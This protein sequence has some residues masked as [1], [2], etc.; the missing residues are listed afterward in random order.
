MT[1]VWLSMEHRNFWDIPR[2]AVVRFE[3]ET[4][5]FDCPFSDELDEYP[6]FFT[7]YRIQ[8]DVPPSG[9]SWLDLTDG[10]E[11]VGHIPARDVRFDPTRR[12][13]IAAETMQ[14]ILSESQEK[15]HA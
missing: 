14:R 10:A 4:Y 2:M 5:V 11:V 9:G 7:V 15:G 3:G 13:A 8:R 1:E 6:D 12:R